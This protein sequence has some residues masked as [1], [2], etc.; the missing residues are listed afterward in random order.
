MVETPLSVDVPASAMRILLGAV[1]L[2]FCFTLMAM[3]FP[4]VTH[5]REH[6]ERIPLL[7]WLVRLAGFGAYAVAGGWVGYRLRRLRPEVPM[8]VVLRLALIAALVLA[9]LAWV[10]ALLQWA[11]VAGQSLMALGFG[12]WLMRMLWTLLGLA[13][14]LG[15]AALMARVAKMHGV[16]E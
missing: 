10:L 9:L 5:V 2:G 11:L 8:S 12:Y 4:W 3:L 1:L 15:S 6:P 13:L 16:V 7:I 14:A